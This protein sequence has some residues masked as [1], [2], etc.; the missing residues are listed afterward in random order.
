MNDHPAP[1][2]R[3]SLPGLALVVGLLAFLIADGRTADGPGGSPPSP[4]GDLPS[5]AG[6]IT[7]F[8]V[9]SSVVIA[10]FVLLISWYVVRRRR[11][12]SVPAEPSP[13]RDRRTLATVVLPDSDIETLVTASRRTWRRR[14]M[15]NRQFVQAV[16]DLLVETDW[17]RPE[18][19]ERFVAVLR[20]ATEEQLSYLATMVEYRRLPR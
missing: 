16:D 1:G 8:G 5:S 17:Q 4:G 15:P 14:P 10:L 12:R 2:R 7:A 11:T 19:V 20:D 9:A 6:S 13:D 18:E 3:G